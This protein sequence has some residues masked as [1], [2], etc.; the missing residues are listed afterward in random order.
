[1]ASSLSQRP[2]IQKLLKINMNLILTVRF[3]L[4]K[5]N[6]LNVHRITCLSDPLNFIINASLLFQFSFP[7]LKIIFSYFSK[8]IFLKLKI[9]PLVLQRFFMVEN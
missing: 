4:V 5:R 1:V 7:M 8:I 3:I 9:I 6:F 2:L